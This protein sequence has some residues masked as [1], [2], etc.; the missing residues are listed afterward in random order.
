MDYEPLTELLTTAQ[1]LASDAPQ[2]H[3]DRPNLCFS[4]PVIK[5]D[6]DKA[7]AS[8]AT[9]VENRFTTQINHQ[10][11]MEPENSVAYMEGEGEDT[12]LVV[13]GRS[14][15]IHLHMAMLQACPGI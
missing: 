11:P 5:G 4:Q 7:F 12:E 14:I 6:A 8:A 10:A 9:V 15:N 2:I 1:A 13:I 3:P